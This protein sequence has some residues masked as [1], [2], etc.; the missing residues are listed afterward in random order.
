VTVV[1]PLLEACDVP[2]GVN[3]LKTLDF[4][5][6]PRTSERY[7]VVASRGKF[8]EEAIEQALRAQSSYLG[9]M[10]S[11]KRGHEL[12]LSLERKGEAAEK[13]AAICLP[14]G[15]DIGAETPEEIALSIMAEVISRR[16]RK[17]R[18]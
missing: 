18:E 12:R 6:L 11:Y 5:L 9:L 14:A 15:I 4:S 10:A 16:R 8:D 2:A 13:L 3:V 17:V 7:V 1:D